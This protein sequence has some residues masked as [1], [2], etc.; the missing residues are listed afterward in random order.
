MS[1]VR[2]HHWAGLAL[3]SLVGAAIL[4]GPASSARSSVAAF[5]LETRD[6]V[7]PTRHG[8]VYLE[9]VHPIDGKGNVVTAPAILTYSPY[10]GALGRNG[11]ASRWVPRGYA[12]ATADLVGTGNSGGCW[13]YGGRREKESGYD[14][15]EWVA[16]QGWSTGR[17]AM[18]GGSYEGTT[19]TAV[20]VTDPPHLTT[21]V[22][23]AAIS[24]W[25]EYA[26]SGGIRYFAN[27]ESP[28]DE[29]VDTPLAFDFG[30]A[31]PP[32]LDVT[33]PTWG[34]RV[35]STVTPCDEVEHTLRGYDNDT[36][37][38]DAF[39]LERD[40]VVDAGQIDV[41]VLVAHNWG[42]WN[43]KQEE[44]VNLYRALANAPV[45]RLY[46]G[47]RYRG[48]GRP[49][50]GYAATVDRWLDHYLLGIAN[51]VPDSITAVTSQMADY[52]GAL[53]NYAGP[54]PSTANV[55]LFAQE[56]RA[57]ADYPWKLLPKS[58]RPPH[59]PK[60]AVFSFTTGTNTEAAANA[61]PRANTQW[62]WFETDPLAQDVR[63]FGNIEVR[64]W[65]TI[66]RSW[67]TYTP[68]IV[69]VDPADRISGP[70]LLQA[71]GSTR[72]PSMTRA[73]LD[74]RYRNGLSSP[75]AVTPGESFGMRIVAKPQDYTFRKGHL[76]GLVIQTEILEWNLPK[77]YSGC[78]SAACA[79]VRIDWELGKT[80]VVLPVVGAPADPGKLFS[81]GS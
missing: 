30:F 32:P 72:I 24:R 25:Y 22:P 47:S 12:R 1:S 58:P 37:E 46:M 55:T 4:I 69:D 38:Y 26:Y 53:G 2:P 76:I 16:A 68:T 80:R 48:H 60:S 31:I 17:V 8:L 78:T 14:L 77:P 10:S 75:V 39:W 51:G 33:D 70:D 42:D 64:L 9:V 29:G 19:A 11:D 20:A 40:Y 43:V 50:L 67:I 27:N 7:L 36:P 41:P 44:G 74:S 61:N 6:Y 63:V 45:K 79:S 62:L 59:V 71:T 65:S 81:A 73:W 66:A 35:R 5:G 54:W 23:E 52:R 15:V 49:T 13:D 28:S 3:V 57:D 34:D 21:I 18:M 56:D